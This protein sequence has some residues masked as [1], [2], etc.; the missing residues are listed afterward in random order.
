M[1]MDEDSHDKLEEVLM[2]LRHVH[3]EVDYHSS[4]HHERVSYDEFRLGGPSC[5]YW[6]W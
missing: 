1:Q 5:E 4:A 3:V 2:A 6:L